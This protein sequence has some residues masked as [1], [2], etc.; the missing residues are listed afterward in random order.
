MY[1]AETRRHHRK[2]L[3]WV[4]RLETATA[5]LYEDMARRSKPET[6]RSLEDV[7]FWVGRTMCEILS[8]Q[9]A[10]A[11]DP[12]LAERAQTAISA[13]AAAAERAKAWLEST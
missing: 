13:A 9:S 7:W 11:R 10:L 1:G 6:L 12:E 4:V 5:G 8:S 3:P 2:V